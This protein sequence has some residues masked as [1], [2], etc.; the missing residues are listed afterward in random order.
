MKKQKY[1]IQF[2]AAVWCLSL[3]AAPFF[4]H[5]GK[6]LSS[7]SDFLYFFYSPLCHQLDAFSF[8]LFGE[9]F[10]V[11]IRCSSIYFSFFIGT[12]CALSIPAPKNIRIFLLI[13]FLP[14]LFD[15]GF[16]TVGM[17][18]SSTVSRIVTGS[19][20]GF[21]LAVALT[22]NLNET[23]HYLISSFSRIKNYAFKTR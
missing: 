15:V 2:S 14:T 20:L 8:H 21:G 19:L 6:S 7:F 9:K 23:F 13:I 12:L 18:H 10:A 1:Y 11:C 17:Y 16:N 22:D 5:E 3:V 4:A